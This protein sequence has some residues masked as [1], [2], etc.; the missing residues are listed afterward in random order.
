MEKEHF[1]DLSCGFSTANI[2]KMSRKKLASESAS[3]LANS[4]SYLSGQWISSFSDTSSEFNAGG[5]R[6][7][8]SASFFPVRSTALCTPGMGVSVGV[9]VPCRRFSFMSR[10]I[11]EENYESKARASP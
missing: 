1:K 6:L 8:K 3:E 5:E 9:Q 11:P 4:I 7:R 2:L 10:K